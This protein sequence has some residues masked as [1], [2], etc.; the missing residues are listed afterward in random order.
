MSEKSLLEAKAKTCQEL[1]DE[2]PEA[3]GSPGLLGA[4]NVL[5]VGITEKIQA[6]Q[7]T[8]ERA[9]TLFV[10]EKMA[11]PDRIEPAWN[12]TQRYADLIT[13]VKE[14]EPFQAYLVHC[15]MGVKAGG[16]SGTGGLRVQGTL[17]PAGANKS[18]L[19]GA[20]HVFRPVEGGLHWK[21]RVSAGSA[22]PTLLGHVAA[23]SEIQEKKPNRFDLGLAR[24]DGS[25]KTS[26]NL[27]CDLAK[28]SGVV[29]SAK[30]GDAVWKCGAQTDFTRGTVDDLDFCAWVHFPGG[31]IQW[32]F[33][34]EQILIRN[35]DAMQP[36]AAP[37][38]SGSAVAT[39]EHW[40]GLLFAG[41]PTG[42]F[43]A[44][45]L[46]ARGRNPTAA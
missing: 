29:D 41:S 22:V 8:G 2:G 39:A 10:R 34:H 28:N 13:D 38:D 3:T 11:D 20:A 45:P 36:F 46:A 24:L 26:P 30:V 25:Q 1:F 15:G 7:A 17:A 27:R 44:N 21:P 43:L 9:L 37:G 23:R 12:I 33:F 4:G 35:A 42:Y 40:V 14:I 32:A 6:G 5:G 18:F 16:P 19:V 31:P